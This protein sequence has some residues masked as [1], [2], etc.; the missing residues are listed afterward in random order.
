M[1]TPATPF[2]PS[3]YYGP[4]YFCNREEETRTLLQNASAGISTT[5]VSVRRLGKTGLI[6]HVRYKAAKD[7]AT[8]YIDIQGTENLGDLL[9]LLAT[10]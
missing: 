3:G 8:V 5:M 2:P 7:F 9:N 10:S 4:G 1:K 6:Q